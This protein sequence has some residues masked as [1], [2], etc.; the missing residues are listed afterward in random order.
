MLLTLQC[1]KSALF[2]V[3]PSQLRYQ[4]SYRRRT[5]GCWHRISDRSLLETYRI[6]LHFS[7]ILHKEKCIQRSYQTHH[8]NKI[9]SQ[10]KYSQFR[11][12]VLQQRNMLAYLTVCLCRFEFHL[13]NPF[14]IRT[15]LYFCVSQQPKVILR[16]EYIISQKISRIPNLFQFPVTPQC[17]C[18]VHSLL[19]SPTILVCFHRQTF[20]GM[21]KTLAAD[22]Y[23][24]IIMLARSIVGT[25]SPT[26]SRE[27]FYHIIS[28]YNRISSDS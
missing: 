10:N 19:L 21:P 24:K 13:S 23:I 3:C 16:V 28:K 12:L 4:S 5:P 22:P 6:Q 20:H 8:L 17:K 26:I 15:P 9:H 25:A 14:R 1:I 2:C 18:T 27:S 11:F 7:S